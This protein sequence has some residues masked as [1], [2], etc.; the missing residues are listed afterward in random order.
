MTSDPRHTQTGSPVSHSDL[1]KRL[2]ERDAARLF[3]RRYEQDFNEPMRHIWHNEPAKPDISCYFQGKPLDLEIAHLYAT[4]EEAKHV[5]DRDNTD[6]LWHYL[7]ELASVNPCDRLETALLSLLHSK[8]QKHYDS[9]R[10]WLVIRN[11]SP[12][13]TRSE[14]LNVAMS[15]DETNY[16]FEQ[17]WLLPD[18]DGELPLIQIA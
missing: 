10:V 2:L 17:I 14:L 13:W 15:F 8:A 12:L 3:M 1:E 6:L 18:F 4:S 5:R 9:D 7:A 11:V 16:P